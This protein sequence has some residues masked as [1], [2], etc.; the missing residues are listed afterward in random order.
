MALINTTSREIQC[1]LVYYGIG[2]C[3]K[4]ANIQY[5]HQQSPS[6]M[7]GKMLKVATARDEATFF[8]LLPLDLGTVRGYRVRFHLVSVPGW[9]RYE[10]VR[11]TILQ[12]LDGIVFVTDSRRER[13]E[14]NFGSL[15]ELERHMHVLGKDL[16]ELPCVMQWNKRDLPDV[17]AID[18]LEKYLNRRHLP[19]FEATALTGIGVFP[20][21]RQV[22]A[23]IMAR[24]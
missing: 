6:E 18:I 20:T 2:Q 15:V 16:A 1:K 3:G 12:G 22:S 19:S 5:I 24:L 10:Q 8:E 11:A 17:L 14:E 21:L 4:T 9:I 23:Q 13:L 7:Q